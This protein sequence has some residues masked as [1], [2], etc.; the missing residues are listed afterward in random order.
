[1]RFFLFVCTVLSFISC[2]SQEYLVQDIRGYD[3]KSKKN[4]QG[5]DFANVR[6]VELNNN[7]EKMVA[8]RKVL[9]DNSSIFIQDKDK[10]LHFSKDG[11][12][13]NTIGKRGHGRGE[14]VVLRT[15]YLES[16]TNVILVDSYRGG[17][18]RYKSDGTFVDET[19]IGKNIY[20]IQNAYLLSEDSLFFSNYIMNDQ[21]DIYQILN[22]NTKK[23]TVVS[24]TNLSTKNKMYP[25]GR[26]SFSVYNGCVKYVEPFD[27]KIYELNGNKC[28]QYSTKQKLLDK[29]EQSEIK[30]FSLESYVHLMSQGG[31]V[32]FTDIFE[33]NNYLLTAFSDWEY[34]L[35]DKRTNTCRRY[36]YK[37]NDDLTSI[38]IVRI[39]GTFNNQLVGL[40]NTD[41]LRKVKNYNHKNK[42]LEKL[43]S[44]QN[45][46]DTYLLLFYDLK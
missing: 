39:V 15:F 26:N 35:L 12:L 7:N 23:N 4:G 17:L 30:D 40:L 14:Y 38:P 45:K 36:S 10:V 44:Y 27:N 3:A 41:D 19:R 34:T 5:V 2:N 25:V 18:L 13:E 8:P 22:L 21:S 32:G 11:K 24:H 29:D 43:M 6:I 20:N 31:F 16:K 1:M 9:F 28:Y 46:K 42:I 37:L 33:I